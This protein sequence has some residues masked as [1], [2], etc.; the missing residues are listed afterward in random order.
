[1][2]AFGSCLPAAGDNQNWQPLE[3]PPATHLPEPLLI[4]LKAVKQGINFPGE[5][6]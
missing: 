4:V 1:M 2:D 5:N 6:K 3:R